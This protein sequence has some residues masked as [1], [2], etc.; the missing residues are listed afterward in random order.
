MKLPSSW[1]Q[2]QTINACARVAR[3]LSLL[4]LESTGVHG[5]QALPG[6]ATTADECVLCVRACVRGGL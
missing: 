6:R 4:R 5:A 3:L 1:D 2:N